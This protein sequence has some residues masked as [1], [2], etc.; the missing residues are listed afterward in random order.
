MSTSGEHFMYFAY[1]SNLLKERLQLANPSAIFHTTGR[2]KDYRLNFGLQGEQ[3]NRWHGGVAT[4]E[5]KEGEEVWGVIWRMDNKHLTN[6]DQQEQVDS[7]MY[8]PLEVMVMAG[9][10]M[11]LLCRTYRMNNFYASLPSPQYKQ[12]VCLGAQQNGLP[13]Q[14]MRRLEEMQTNS[15]SG[16]SILDQ[17]S[18]AMK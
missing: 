7:G 5:P 15:Y 2:L 16:P 17:I 6:L 8:C 1:G 14:Y 11:T 3:V 13:M 10:G 9:D 12:V 18:Q 4:I